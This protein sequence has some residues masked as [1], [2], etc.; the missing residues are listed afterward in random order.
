VALA[1]AII[2]RNIASTEANSLCYPTPYSASRRFHVVP[3]DPVDV[4]AFRRQLDAVSSRSDLSRMAS[5]CNR[6]EQQTGLKAWGEMGNALAAMGRPDASAK[7]A[8]LDAMITAA[9]LGRAEVGAVVRLGDFISWGGWPAVTKTEL[10]SAL[11][12]GDRIVTAS[13]RW[14]TS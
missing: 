13:Y 14:Q 3:Q 11:V 12:S 1:E 2:R 8:W 7:K 9:R 5:S 10:R 4:E 6:L